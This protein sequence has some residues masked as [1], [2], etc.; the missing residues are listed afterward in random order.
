MSAASGSDAPRD[1]TFD[2][3]VHAMR[4]YGIDSARLGHTF[5]GLHRL[6]QA[7][8]Q[9]LVAI[10]SSEATGVP[11]TPSGLRGHLGLSSGGTTYVIDR[12][13]RAGHV[14]RARD[15]SRDSRVVHLHQTEQ[16]MATA[17]EFFGPLGQRMDELLQQFTPAEVDVIQRFAVAASGILHDHIESLEARM[18]AV[19]GA[20]EAVDPAEAAAATEA[21]EVTEAEAAAV[22][23]QR[24]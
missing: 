23:S 5:A 2:A 4:H 3:I 17:L 22:E 19:A 14:R 8:L 20:T 24:N 15:R 9:A 1:D 21:A 11:L 7:D 6:Q 12:L 13:E 16:G 10:I 18:P